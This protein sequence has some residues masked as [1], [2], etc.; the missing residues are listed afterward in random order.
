MFTN[1]GM[2]LACDAAVRAEVEDEG[3]IMIPE[4]AT[5]RSTQANALRELL[6]EDASRPFRIM[7][8]P[9]LR[10]KLVRVRMPCFC[11]QHFPCAPIMIS[12]VLPTR[13][14]ASA[15]CVFFTD[16]SMKE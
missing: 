7:H 14:M 15:D 16:K 10:V 8:G 6:I 12:E 5:N 1:S 4:L 13:L 3:G 2:S 11:W 9:L